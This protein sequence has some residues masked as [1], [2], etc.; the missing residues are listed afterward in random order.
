M[1]RFIK[2]AS[3]CLYA[4]AGLQGCRTGDSATESE[5]ASLDAP[6]PPPG[7]IAN[8]QDWDR[9]DKD[10]RLNVLERD[11]GKYPNLK[12]T[13]KAPLSA[14]KDPAV[15]QFAEK[16]AAH[17]RANGSMVV[18]DATHA[19]IGDTSVFAQVLLL[20]G[21][22]I[23]GGEVHFVQLGCDMPDESPQRFKAPNEAEEAS[24][25]RSAETV[26]SAHGAFNHDGVPIECADFME[27]GSL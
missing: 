5:I 14:V 25:E 20:D 24:C 4:V 1:R 23:L 16:M 9:L 27:W 8:V 12:M 6:S 13:E 19:R 11:F 26:W 21:K 18:E 15:R 10:T 17:M 22:T 7:A 3:L 2:L